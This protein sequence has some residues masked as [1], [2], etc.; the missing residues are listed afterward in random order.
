MRTKEVPLEDVPPAEF[1]GNPIESND[2]EKATKINVFCDLVVMLG[3]RYV[4]VRG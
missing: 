4:R 3:H 1:G 2:L